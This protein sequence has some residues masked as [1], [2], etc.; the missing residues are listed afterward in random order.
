[1]A[2]GHIAALLLA[3]WA[4]VTLIPVP[5][6]GA[7]VLTPQGNLPTYVDKLIL[8]HLHYG[9]NTWFLSYLGLGASVLLGVL[10]GQ[11]LMSRRPPM[12]KVFRLLA[13]GAVS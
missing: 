2:C 6:V 7:G 3:Y 4:M 12:S 11:M 5:G 8:G 1:M 13:A 9:W 10:A